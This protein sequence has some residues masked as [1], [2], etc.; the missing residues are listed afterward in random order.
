MK[1]QNITS[2]DVDVVLDKQFV[3][4]SD[5]EKKKKLTFNPITNVFRVY[6]NS[7]NVAQLF[8]KNNEQDALTAY[9]EI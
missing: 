3:I 7:N 1:I 4:A 5:T 9:N 2:A 6:H 8:H